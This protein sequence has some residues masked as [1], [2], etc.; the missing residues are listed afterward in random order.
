[1]TETRAVVLS[2]ETEAAQRAE[3][4]AQARKWLRTP[5][6]PCGD[7]LGAGVDCGMLLVRAFVDAGLVTP[8]D[9]RPYPADWMMHN[10]G[11]RYLGFVDDLCGVVE[12]P[13]PGDIAVFRYGRCYSHGGVISAVGPTKIIHAYSQKR[14]VVED[15]LS[16][17]ADL[18][19]PAR[20]IKYYSFWAALH[21]VE[22]RS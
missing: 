20:K 5:Y 18:C 4:V 21:Q 13:Q 14:A 19:K 17:N 9:P 2:A 7:I 6:H 10:D 8:F 11:E 15:L 3:V 16:R 12:E 22:Q 1:M